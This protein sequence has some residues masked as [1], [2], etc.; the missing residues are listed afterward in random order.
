MKK[1]KK[2]GNDDKKRIASCLSAM[3]AEDTSMRDSTFFV[4]TSTRILAPLYE[5]SRMQVEQGPPSRVLA[6][7]PINPAAIFR[8]E[9]RLWLSAIRRRLCGRH[10]TKN[11]YYSE[12]TRDIPFELFAVVV[13][14]V[15]VMPGFCDPFCYYGNNKKGEVI[16][17]TSLRLVAQL[18][19]MLSGYLEEEV[20][21]YF[22]RNLSGFKF[23]HKVAVVA[24][25]SK[26]FALVYKT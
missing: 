22:K 2:Q 9:S 23:G 25:E 1:T 12:I 26:D 15:K 24:S 3:V 10:S 7:Y 8:K 17:F 4:E 14:L 13:K 19:S 18:L 11:P 21:T 6:T 16:S 20:V 5:L